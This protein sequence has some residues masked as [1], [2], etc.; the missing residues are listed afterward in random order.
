MLWRS[1]GIEPSA[2]LGHSVGEFAAACVAGVFSLEDGI[3][4]IARRARLM[5][6]LPAGGLMAAVFASESQVSQRN[7]ALRR[8]NRDRR[9]ERAGEHRHLRRRSGRRGSA[10]AASKPK[11]SSPKP[12]ATSHAFHSHRMDPI[13]DALR[14]AAAEAVRIEAGNR[15]RLQP[16]GRA[17]RRADAMPIRPTGAATP[18]RRCGSPKACR[19]WPIGAARSFWKSGRARR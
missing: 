12:L 15:H 16:D 17:G 7:R 18:A 3:R 2:V 6:S 10:G 4:L 1:W 9:A 14:E 5:Q 19:R 13:L 11:T 8:P